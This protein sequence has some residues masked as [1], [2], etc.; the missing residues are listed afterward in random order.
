MDRCY[1]IGQNK[2]VFVYKLISDSAIERRIIEVQ[3][4][5]KQLIEKVIHSKEVLD[6]NVVADVG[7]VFN[8]VLSSKQSEI[9]EESD[10]EAEFL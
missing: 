8:E 9:V 3:E 5:K 2:S 1:R 10:S 4:Q 7:D 6:E